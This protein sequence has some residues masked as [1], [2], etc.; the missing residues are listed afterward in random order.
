[1]AQLELKNLEKVFPNRKGQD[2]RAVKG[3]DLAVSKGEFMVLLG[4]SGCGKS[5]TLR[6]IAGLEEATGGSIEIDGKVV[7]NVDPKDRDVAMVFQNFAL[8][9]HMTVYENMAFG[10]KLRGCDKSDIETR[11]RAA[12]KILELDAL[13]SRRPR[14]LS[15][16]QRQR[17]AVGRAIVRDPRVF[18][19]DEPLSNLDARMRASMR[20]QISRLH[21]QLGTTMIY[22]THDQMEAM[23]MGDRICVMKEGEIMQIDTPMKVYHEPANTFV[24]SFMGNPP[25]NLVNGTLIRL[26]G[27]WR[28][29]ESEKETG[30][31]FE[32]PLSKRLSDPQRLAK[33]TEV[34]MGIR[35]ENMRLSPL[36][37]DSQGCEENHI[38]GITQMVETM[39]SDSIV[40]IDTGLNEMAVNVRGGGAPSIGD[41]L[42]LKID[43]DKM[44]F[45]D[46]E[47]G[48]A[49]PV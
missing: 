14:A 32:I 31:G 19:F 13:L 15:G 46:K 41:E 34:I 40:Y 16:G 45:F 2:V 24:A 21:R 43:A 42:L 25:M 17:V 18:L 6:M 49:L 12:A 29:R 30:A 10:L 37:E 35:A 28:F 36:V 33:D 11:V 48:R 9:P 8:Y 26:G 44:R 47:T 22:V 4:P 27:E 3:I 23:T 39:G 38:S 7:N 5:T 20:M 1:M